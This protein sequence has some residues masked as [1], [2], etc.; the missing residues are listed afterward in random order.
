MEYMPEIASALDVYADEITTSTALNPII[1]IDCH[2][3]EIKEILNDSLYI[4]NDLNINI[5]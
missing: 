5:K 2:N 3:H 4:L 1:Q